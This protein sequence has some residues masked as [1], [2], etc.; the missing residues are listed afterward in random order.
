VNYLQLAQS[1]KRE[2]GLSGGG[3]ISVVTATGDDARI[4]QWVN[5]AHRDICLMHESWLFRRGSALGQTSSMAMP[6]DL[7]APGFALSDFADW[8]P[9]NNEYK[10]SAWRVSDGQQAEKTLSY[11]MWDE[12]RARYVMGSHDAGAVTHWTTDP[13]G[14]LMVGPTPDSAHMVRADY[15]KDVVDMTADTD[16]PMIPA[17]FHNLIVWRALVEY[18]GFDAAAEVY[19]RAD[20]NYATGLSALLQA[21]LPMRWIAARPLA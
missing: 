5:W 17:R 10:P 14:Q 20:R 21:Q 2:S 13:S 15:I 11:L 6:H 19:Q 8:K 1:V 7:I 9:E 18:G 16:T 12:F 4:F 3:P